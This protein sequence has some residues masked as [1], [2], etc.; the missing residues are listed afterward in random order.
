MK[1]SPK[2]RADTWLAN[3]PM[4]VFALTVVV[5]TIGY[6]AWPHVSRPY[7]NLMLQIDPSAKR[8]FSYGVRH[9]DALNA[10]AYDIERAHEFFRLAKDL[11]PMYP[12]VDHQLA[13]IAFLRSDYPMALYI[14]NS[15]L[16]RYPT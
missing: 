2:E 6:F 11:D 4:S 8:A 14:I 9:F 5:V 10:R 7:E 16:K 1:K 12:Y 15:E 3:S 13:R